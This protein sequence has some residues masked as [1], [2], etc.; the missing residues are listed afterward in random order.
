MST[1]LNNI[2]LASAMVAL[3]EQVRNQTNHQIITKQ[4]SITFEEAYNM[5]LERRLTRGQSK[6]TIRNF[7]NTMK[8]FLSYLTTIGKDKN[9]D[10][11]NNH[12][13]NRYVIGLRSRDLAATTINQQITHIKSLFK[14]LITKK[15][16][17]IDPTDDLILET[18]VKKFRRTLTDSEIKKVILSFDLRNKMHLLGAL[19]FLVHNDIA[20]R[21]SELCR[22]RI[23]NIN[24]KTGEIHYYARKNNVDVVA[25]LSPITI[26]SL[27]VY[28]KEAHDNKK[29]GN[30]FLKA[31]SNGDSFTNE[32]VTENYVRN[33][34]K[35]AGDRAKLGFNLNTHIIR[36]TFVTRSIELGGDISMVQQLVGHKDIRS[37][38]QYV[39]LSK[40]VLRQAHNSFGILNTLGK[41]RDDNE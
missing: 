16:I 27:K 30:L 14:I 10:G 13:I 19:L 34:Y 40:K 9:L 8:Q 36:R 25:L 20:C 31:S 11:V 41:G 6:G 28:L 32:R 26:V 22:I 4:P 17:E 5:Q 12:D 15:I 29:K 38:V 24:L 1:E 35:S 18:I 21:V 2:D 3:A 33:I 37:T 23:E 39:H 7:N